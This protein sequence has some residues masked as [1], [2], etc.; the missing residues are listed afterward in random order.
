MTK[1]ER[2]IN[3]DEF[4]TL[5]THRKLFSLCGQNGQN[6]EFGQNGQNRQN[7]EFWTLN[8]EPFMSRI[9]RS[10]RFIESE[11]EIFKKMKR[12]SKS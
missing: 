2:K 8:T 6:V 10:A 4:A 1:T 7:V 9:R 12:K 11:N 5:I 3:Y